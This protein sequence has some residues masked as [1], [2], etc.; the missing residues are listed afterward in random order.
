MSDIVEAAEA[1]I[2]ALEALIAAGEQLPI[3]TAVRLRALLTAAE[4][5][6][7]ELIIAL[8]N[9]IVLGPTTYSEL[10]L[11]EP[12]AGE[13]EQWDNLSRIH[14]DRKAVSVVSGTP[15]AIIKQVPAREFYR[16]ARYIGRFLD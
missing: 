11:R 9:P 15:E 14:A 2:E 3:P 7:D 16:A 10:K 13:I 1:T 4:A 5:L 6:P 12:T 8:R